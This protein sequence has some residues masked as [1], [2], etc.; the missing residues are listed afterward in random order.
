MPLK[1]SRK[2]F[3]IGFSLL[4]LGGLAFTVYE[5]LFQRRSITLTR[6]GTV[7][8]EVPGPYLYVGS[9]SRDI[10][11]GHLTVRANL[12]DLSSWVA[13]YEPNERDELFLLDISGPNNISLNKYW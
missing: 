2:K 13:S 10:V 7:S 8:M 4:I 1:L 9:K 3:V 5:S 6:H 12:F 11:G